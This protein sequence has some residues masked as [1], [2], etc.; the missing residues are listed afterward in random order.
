VEPPTLARDRIDRVLLDLVQPSDYV[1]W[2][3]FSRQRLMASAIAGSRLGMRTRVLDVGCGHG[4]LSLTLAESAGFDVVAMDVLESRVRSVSSR[5]AARD[6]DAAAR[7]RIVRADA[8]SLPFQDESFDAVAATEVLEHLDE[9]GRML[10][11]ARRVLRPEGRFVMTTPNSEALPYRL[12]RFLPDSTVSRLAAS[13]TQ[14]TLHPELLHDHGAA[15]GPSGHPDR[16]RREG[17]TLQELGRLGAQ[18]GLQMESAYRYRI[19]IPD[20]V[21]QVTPRVLSRSVAALGTR[22]LPLGL[23]L[24]AEF[25]KT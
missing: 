6:P 12:L 19:P 15:A 22:P 10:S 17:F 9:P 14:E 16:H 8:E 11:E 23:Q 3:Y 24:Y 21:M 13:L 20:R 2:E 1:K 25:T 18:A 5:K 7:V 4:A